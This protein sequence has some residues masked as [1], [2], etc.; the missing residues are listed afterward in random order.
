MI[1][2]M[3]FSFLLLLISSAHGASV[4]PSAV[5]D[6]AD[7][8]AAPETDSAAPAR[9]GGGTAAREASVPLTADASVLD[10]IAPSHGESLDQIRQRHIARLEQALM[11]TRTAH[12]ADLKR[13]N[14]DLERART[15]REAAIR[16]RDAVLAQFV[17]ERAAREAAE[18]AVAAIQEERRRLRNRNFARDILITQRGKLGE[19]FEEIIP[20]RLTLENIQAIYHEY[21]QANRAAAG[22]E[23]ANFDRVR[24]AAEAFQNHLLLR[25]YQRNPIASDDRFLGIADCL[26]LPLPADVRPLDLRIDLRDAAVVD[27]CAD[28]LAI[29]A[30]T[31]YLLPNL[32]QSGKTALVQL[33][34]HINNNPAARVQFEAV[35]NHRAGLDQLFHEARYG[36]SY[37]KQLLLAG[38]A[39]LAAGYA[40]HRY[41]RHQMNRFNKDIHSIKAAVKDENKVRALIAERRKW[42]YFLPGGAETFNNNIMKK[43]LP[44]ESVTPAMA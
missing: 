9:G 22:F 16:E 19:I 44:V 32:D 39:L 1:K 18:Q 10:S 11:K 29:I 20:E 12:I 43:L 3:I 23:A 28:A 24:R 4:L 38:A 21:Y 17:Q 41:Y 27:R 40:A 7:D 35:R 34:D 36:K 31:P 42:K 33:L 6:G 2:T 15:V 30:N 5:A 8:P 37:S 26:A 25:T 14:E 13:A